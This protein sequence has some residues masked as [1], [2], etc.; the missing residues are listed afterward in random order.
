VT[1]SKP[2]SVVSPKNGYEGTP[3]RGTN[4]E[5]YITQKNL[6]KYFF[7]KKKCHTRT[8]MNSKPINLSKWTDNMWHSDRLLWK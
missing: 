8:M 4:T 7:L 1:T 2:Y 3:S 6:Y 5:L